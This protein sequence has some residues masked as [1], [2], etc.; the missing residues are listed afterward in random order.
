[1]FSGATP[2][3]RR[4]LAASRQVSKERLRPRARA[5]VIER[6]RLERARSA[7]AQPDDRED[8][9]RHQQD[10]RLPP[11]SR[12]RAM[13]WAATVRVERRLAHD[14]E[15]E[16]EEGDE[17]DEVDPGGGLER[18]AGPCPHPEEVKRRNGGRRSEENLDRL[19]Q[20]V[21]REVRSKEPHAGIVPGRVAEDRRHRRLEDDPKDQVHE[22]REKEHRRGH[23]PGPADD[24]DGPRARGLSRLGIGRLRQ[25]VHSSR[26]G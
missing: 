23:Q 5:D 4:R 16:T 21:V 6:L 14:R 18:G 19:D 20:G 1:M 13:G 10:P 9:R 2:S 17:V 24:G 3:A 22:S 15:R 7:P 26:R 8:E 25:G 12:C 11:T